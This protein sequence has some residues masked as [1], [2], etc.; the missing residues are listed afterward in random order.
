MTAAAV[1]VWSVVGLAQTPPQAPAVAKIEVK[2]AALTLKVGEKAQLEAVARDAAGNI[3]QAPVTF[4]SRARRAVTVTPEGLVQAARPGTH[5]IVAMAGPPPAGR[6]APAEA[7]QTEIIVTVPTP[8]ITTVRLS[9]PKRY[10][11]GTVVPITSSLVDDTGAERDDVAVMWRSSA[12]AIAEMDAFGNLIAHRAG[13]ATLTATAEGAS[14]T[15]DVRIEA[16][17]VATLELSAPAL[18][19][20]RTGDVVRFTALAKDAQARAV[21]D[22]PV[23][24]AVTGQASKD[25]IAPG[26]AAQ[27]DS[28]GVFVAERSGIYTVVATSGAHTAARTFAVVPRDVA[29]QVEVVGHGAVRDRHTSDLWI[30]E[31]PDGKDYAITGTW[32]ASGH[33]FF[34]DVT[35][36]AKPEKIGEVQVDAR[37]VNDVKISED[38]KVAVISRE[39]ASNRRNGFVVIDI[40]NPRQGLPILSRYDDELTGG[41]HNVFVHKQHVYAVNNGRRFDIVSIEDPKNPTRVGRFELESP[42]HSIHDVWVVDGVAFS[43]NW[44]DGVVAI[45]VGGGGKGGS[46]TNPVMLGQYKYPSG[47][48]HAAFPYKSKSTGK[49]YVFAGDE[50]FPA[51]LNTA[52][53]GPT[54]RAA[55]WIHVIEWDD[56]A[57]PREV[58][59]YQVPEAGT[60]NL[61]VED[62]KMYV[63]YYNG[64]LRVVDVSG[65]LRGDLYRQGREIARFY[66]DDPKGVIA[67]SPMVWGPQPYKGNVF[68]S[69]FNSG[70]WIVRLKPGPQPRSGESQ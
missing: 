44:S 63:G 54:I 47:W 46:P 66:S 12:P 52:A 27:I 56:W 9:G 61:W 8:A 24:F 40:S 37:T 2:P 34:W 7:V 26:A 4:F 21:A 35:D 64:G 14:S 33:A 29:M 3:V 55:G 17:P 38:G 48:N 10:F 13:S 60:H 11:A 67:N 68:F 42:G 41:V 22:V 45:D 28:D 49:F 1:A 65:E 25:I 57:N 32:G 6:A 51:G 70:L 50:S 59:R 18:D 36:P 19:K 23:Q 43:S 62:D 16:N 58:A 20:V 5:T 15:L 69:D 31:G 39:G 30:W 53:G